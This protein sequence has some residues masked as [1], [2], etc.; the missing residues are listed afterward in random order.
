MASW[1]L[2]ISNLIKLRDWYI[3]YQNTWTEKMSQ[4]E[5]DNI[6]EEQA[7]IGFMTTLVQQRGINDRGYELVYARLHRSYEY[8][9]QLAL[10]RLAE[11]GIPE[12]ENV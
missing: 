1:G 7:I 9:E 10:D 11:Q 4:D 6:Q 2:I 3:E 12:G 5:Y 8:Q